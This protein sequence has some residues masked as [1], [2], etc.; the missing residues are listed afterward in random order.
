MTRRM[1]VSYRVKHQPEQTVYSRQCRSGAVDTLTFNGPPVP[2][3]PRYEHWRDAERKEL[4]ERWEVW[5]W[6]DNMGHLLSTHPTKDEARAALLAAR[7]TRAGEAEAKELKK[8]ITQAT[9]KAI[10]AAG[11]GAK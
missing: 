4:P 7:R 2:L 6:T 9:E 1:K 3:P 10:E 8:A 11:W 5:C